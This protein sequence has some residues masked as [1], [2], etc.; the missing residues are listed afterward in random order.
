M[1]VGNVQIE[2]RRLVG[3]AA[4]GRADGVP[5]LLPAGGRADGEFRCAECGYGVIVRTELPQCPMCRGRAWQRVPGGE[6]VHP[7]A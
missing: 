6:L 3:R 1:G 4:S 5:P 2:S 7:V